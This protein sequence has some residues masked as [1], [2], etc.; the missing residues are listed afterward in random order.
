MKPDLTPAQVKDLILKGSER[1]GRV[2][3]INP[4]ETMKLAGFA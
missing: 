1:Q 4:R 3:L 2:N